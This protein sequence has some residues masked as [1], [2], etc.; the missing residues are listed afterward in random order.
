M[1]WHPAFG[2]FSSCPSRTWNRFEA[3]AAE[4]P[5]CQGSAIRVTGAHSTDLLLEIEVTS[6]PGA[7]NQRPRHRSQL[8]RRDRRHY[9]N[10]SDGPPAN[11]VDLSDIGAF[12]SIP[13]QWL[14]RTGSAWGQYA[15]TVYASP[16]SAAERGPATCEPCSMFNPA[17]FADIS[18]HA[19][20]DR[21][22]HP[23]QTCSGWLRPTLMNRRLRNEAGRVD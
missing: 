22:H 4:R 9:G 17:V 20:L 8:C 3:N 6:R 2:Q 13:D 5:I 19:N 23:N 21:R 14:R 12:A 15:T 11:V 1:I 18:P 10:F 7:I 16:W